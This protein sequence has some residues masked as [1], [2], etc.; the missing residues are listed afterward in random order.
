M[1]YSP[2][3]HG[4]PADYF[5]LPLEEIHRRGTE[6]KKKLGDDLLILAHHYQQDSTYW[7]SDVSGDSLFLARQ[8]SKTPAKF[9]I[10]CGVH[11]MAESS[12]IITNDDQITLLPD[13]S[14][15]C[16]MADMADVKDVEKCWEVLTGACGA[17]SF[18]PITYINSTAEIKAFCAKNGGAVC[19]SSNSHKI[20][21]WALDQKK[22]VLFVP[23]QHLGRNTAKALGIPAKEIG[24]WDRFDPQ[25]NLTRNEMRNSKIILWSGYCPVHCNFTVSEINE[26]RSKNPGI[27]VIVHPECPE[28]IVNLADMSG[29]TDKIIEAI[30][31]SEPKT[32]WAVGTEANLVRRIAKKMYQEQKKEVQSI[33]A[34]VCVCSTMNNIHPAHVLWIMENLLKG[35]IINQVTVPA[36]TKRFAELALDRMLDLS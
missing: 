2:P 33:N 31:E 3:T 35:I 23:D 11:F 27:K 4:I 22:R 30:S 8:A 18:I 26:L 14:A 29:S 20:L 15:G 19:T 28:E 32:K 1:N 34:D 36:E 12:D 25:G 17:N 21:R 16:P 7:F 13:L 6:A 24:L 10:F 5:K 9:I